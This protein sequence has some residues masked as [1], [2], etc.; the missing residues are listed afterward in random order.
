[1]YLDQ[2]RTRGA[3][4]VLSLKLKDKLEKSNLREEEL[5]FYCCYDCEKERGDD[6]RNQ[7]FFP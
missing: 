6:E 5:I 1:M 2:V 7:T 4:W 3:T